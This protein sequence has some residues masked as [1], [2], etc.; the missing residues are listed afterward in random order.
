[1]YSQVLNK[2]RDEL[3]PTPIIPSSLVG[4][5]KGEGG[6]LIILRASRASRE[7]TSGACPVPSSKEW[8]HC[9]SRACRGT[10]QSVIII[11]IYLVITACPVR[12]QSYGVIDF[13]EQRGG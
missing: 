5:G 2:C 7:A 3:L 6:I 12:W 11:V 9:E 13:A 1:M 8:R 10:W 4:E